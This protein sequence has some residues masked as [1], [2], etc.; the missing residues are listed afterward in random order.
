M[1]TAAPR[2]ASRRTAASPR[3]DAPPVTTDEVPV[4]SSNGVS[5]GSGGRLPE[6]V[7]S[8]PRSGGADASGDRRYPGGAVGR[9]DPMRR[10]WTWLGTLRARSIALLL[11]LL[12]VGI[13]PLLSRPE[14]DT[15]WF[16]GSAL[17]LTLVA[18]GQ[19]L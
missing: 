12:M 5:R 1:T 11:A 19:S 17:A 13:S 7:G 10:S 3:P 16:F 6:D 15:R 4:R 18:Q 9:R 14:A 2:A 8:G